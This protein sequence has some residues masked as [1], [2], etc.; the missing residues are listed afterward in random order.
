MT[1]HPLGHH[2]RLGLIEGDAGENDPGRPKGDYRDLHQR[3]G[4]AGISP[5]Q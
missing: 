5:A 1:G 4:Y 2:L 3:K